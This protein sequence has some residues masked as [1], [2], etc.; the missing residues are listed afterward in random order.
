[1]FGSAL[2]GQLANLPGVSVRGMVRQAGTL[3]PPAPNV[4]EVVGDMDDTSSLGPAM[5]GVTH[6]F[7]TSPMD[8]HIAAREMAVV[9]AAKAAGHIHIVKIHGAVEHRGDHLSS[10]HLQSIAHIQQSGL[11]WT[12]VSPNSVM[13]TSILPFTRAVKYDAIFG[14][15]GHGKVGM[16]A[17]HDVAAATRTVIMGAEA[18]H[19]GQNYKITG[20]EGVDLYDVAEAISQ[21]I[22]RTV[23]YYDMP[24]AAFAQM[25]LE[26]TGAPS[27]EWL[28][29]NILC[30]L[31][32]WGRGDAA[33]VTDTFTSLTGNQPT[34]LRQWI[35]QH[36]DQF[37]APQTPEDQ[38]A[39]AA[40]RRQY[41]TAGT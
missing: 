34:T 18:D 11:P 36:V 29:I 23:V 25:M 9:D 1:M 31:R 32:A 38:A 19:N 24:E 5:A 27:E 39:A 12:L 21:A 8:D 33:L 26:Q 40:I 7:L 41:A 15:S 3:D 16:V 17:L 37:N 22:G 14:M 28:E 13:E 4:V 10:L 2:I 20:P 35:G 6:V 30:H